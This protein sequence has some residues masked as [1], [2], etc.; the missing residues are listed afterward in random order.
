[1]AV[2]QARIHPFP[3][4]YNNCHVLP[5]SPK[6]GQQVKHAI[7]PPHIYAGLIHTVLKDLCHIWYHLVQCGLLADKDEEDE[8]SAQEVDAADGS[9]D[10]L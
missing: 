7:N 2:R 6:D 9:Q 8:A 3:P 10:K 5:G 1:M 4:S